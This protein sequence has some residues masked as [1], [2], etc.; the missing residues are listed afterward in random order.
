[1]CI[2]LCLPTC[3][4]AVCMPD[5][6]GC[7]KRIGPS[8]TGVT[9]GWELLCGCWEFSPVLEG[10]PVLLNTELAVFQPCRHLFNWIRNPMHSSRCGILITH[11][12]VIE[13]EATLLYV[14]EYQMAIC[15]YYFSDLK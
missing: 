5:I 3:L 1:M 12:Y 2:G 14:I 15:M 4:C 8:G 6:H 11:A 13:I 7:Q 10:Q 9:D